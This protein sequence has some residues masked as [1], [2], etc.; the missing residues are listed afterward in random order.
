M[1][2]SDLSVKIKPFTRNGANNNSTEPLLQDQRSFPTKNQ[3]LFNS[4]QKLSNPGKN[5]SNFS[6]PDESLQTQPLQSISYAS[7]NTS[8][9]QNISTTNLKLDKLTDL[10]LTLRNDSESKMEI[11]LTSF[12]K[13]FATNTKLETRITELERR[14]SLMESNSPSTGANSMLQNNSVAPI[15]SLLS[16]TNFSPNQIS[17]NTTN[18]NNTNLLNNNLP[19]PTNPRDH[20]LSSKNQSWAYI[21]QSS[22]NDSTSLANA[23]ARENLIQQKRTKLISNLSKLAKPRSNYQ[24]NTKSIYVGGFEF[25]KIRTIWK[26]LYNAKF[27]ISRIVNIQWIG[28][29]VLDIVVNADYELQFIS[30]LSQNKKFRILNFNPS[31]NEKAISS[32]AN[33]SI[34]RNFSIRCIKNILNP[35][36]STVCMNHFKSLAEQYCRQNPDLKKLYD[37]EWIK[38]KAAITLQT[39]VLAEKINTN[40]SLLTTDFKNT[41]PTS[42]DNLI[43]SNDTSANNELLTSELMTDIEKLRKLDP[44]HPLLSTSPLISI[45]EPQHTTNE[46]NDIIIGSIEPNDIVIESIEPNDIVIESIEPNETVIESTESAVAASTLEDGNSD[47]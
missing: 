26:A 10:I 36:N 12:D 43:S 7:S 27:Q 33:E 37:E 21:A 31:F 29:T 5:S 39:Q 15:N 22:L 17:S 18:L 44:S 1:I 41:L 11:L 38:A 45:F 30:E 24:A 3:N 28:R 9:S 23:K 40:I 16:N 32:E 34:M 42:N 25:L 46:T 13:L 19:T 2:V 4:D 20:I 14:I 35:K 6:P 8:T 47:Y